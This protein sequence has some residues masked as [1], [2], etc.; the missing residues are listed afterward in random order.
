MVSHFRSVAALLPAL[1]CF[2]LVTAFAHARPPA[3]L[4]TGSNTATNGYLEILPDEYGAWAA[5]FTTGGFGPNSDRFRPSGATLQVAGFSSGFFFFGP[6]GQ[7]ELLTDNTQWQATTNGAGG[8]A[9]SADTSLSRSV[10]TANVASD[11][12]GDGINDNAT[13]AFR[14]F[15]PAGG[16]DLA[17]Q[18]QQRVTSVSPAVSLMQQ[19]YNVTNNG[20]SAITL[21]MVRIFDGDLLWDANFET[22]SV[23]TS[24]NGAGQGP[25]VFIQEPSL[26]THS[27]TMSMLGASSYFGGKHGVLP[28]LGAPPYDFGTDTEVWDANGTPLSWANHIAGVGYNLNGQSGP[29]PV[30]STVPR[31]GFIGME[32]SISLNPLASTGFS[33]LHTYGQTTPVPEPAFGLIGLS[34]LTVLRRRRRA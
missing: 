17:F 32:I 34:A 25:F 2:L 18:L 5:D 27:V 19:N 6:S 30:G 33:L 26:P 4:R 9:F 24:A 23:G 15:S 7:R 14:V 31:D 21:K 20:A 1:A 8:P 3:Q 16:T 12:N 10:I 22:D 11:T 13:S 29:A 28:G